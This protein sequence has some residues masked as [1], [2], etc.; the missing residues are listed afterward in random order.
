MV[1]GLDEIDKMNSY[2]KE[3]DPMNV[4]YRILLGKHE[5]KFLG[6][7]ISTENKIFIATANRLESIPEPIKNRFNAIITLE[8]Y[9]VEDKMI[10][11]RKFIIPQELKEKDIKFSDEVL[12]YIITNFC[13]D[14]GARDIQHNVEKVIRRAIS[15]GNQKREDHSGIIW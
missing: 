3:G 7:G 8:D 11:G 13:E 5:D 15:S 4:L 6:C 2:S 9:S 10:I 14:C 1:I 12:R